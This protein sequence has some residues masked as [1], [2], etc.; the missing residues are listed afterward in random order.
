MQCD[1]CGEN[2]PD[3][4]VARDQQRRCVVCTDCTRLL[5]SRFVNNNPSP[6][7]EDLEE[8]TG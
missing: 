7:S 4:I 8:E 2:K 3:M 5:R 1:V 6:D